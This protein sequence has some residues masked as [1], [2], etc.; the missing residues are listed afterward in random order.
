VGSSPHGET[1][2]GQIRLD[3]HLQDAVAGETK[4]YQYR[5]GHLRLNCWIWF[6]AAELSFA[7]IPGTGQAASDTSV[8]ASPGNEKLPGSSE[9]WAKRR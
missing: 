1:W 2:A 4:L 7:K 9:G 8:R 5:N 6:H 3:F